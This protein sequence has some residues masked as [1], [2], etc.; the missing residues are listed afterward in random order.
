MKHQAGTTRTLGVEK[1]TATEDLRTWMKYCAR[2][3]RVLAVSSVNARVAVQVIGVLH[4]HGYWYLLVC[5]PGW[6]TTWPIPLINRNAALFC[7]SGNLLRPCNP[8]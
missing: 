4:S 3:S 6:P 2:C 1:A 8:V 5:S 7:G